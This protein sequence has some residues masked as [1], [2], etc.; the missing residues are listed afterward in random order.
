MCHPAGQVIEKFGGAE[1]NL[2]H[3]FATHATDSGVGLGTL[4][5]LLAHNSL[6]IVQKCVHPGAAHKKSAMEQYE[7]VLAEIE[8]QTSAAKGVTDLRSQ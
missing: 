5:A 4:A 7:G 6:R 1:R 2:L 3:T 8:R